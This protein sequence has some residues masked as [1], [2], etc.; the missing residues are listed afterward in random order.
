MWILIADDH[1]VL[2]ELVAEMLA[3]FAGASTKISELG[4][5][6]DLLAM[7]HETPHPD[8]ILLD[9]Q[10]PGE[11]GLK[12]VED[13][14]K[15]FPKTRV[16]IMSGNVDPATARK[17]LE[18]GAA[19]FV[20]KSARKNSLSNALRLV[21]TGDNYIAPFIF[22]TRK[23][24]DETEIAP[25][26]VNGLLTER[27]RGVADLLVQ[28]HSNKLIASTLS[29]HELTVR[30]HLRSIYRKI[31]SRRRADAVAK[32]IAANKNA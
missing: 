22:E 19:G 8:V 2:R 17:C 12:S 10:M 4:N 13:V 27:E 28:G 6:G 7:R 21:I 30:S 9:L 25:H 16:L 31:G 14:I 3:D 29:L 5:Y 1:A 32:L 26:Q 20:P 18:L 24:G 15:G 23:P 11:N